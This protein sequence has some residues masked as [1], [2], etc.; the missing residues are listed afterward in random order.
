MKHGRGFTLIEMLVALAI[1][2][3]MSAMAW[4]GLDVLINSR[5]VARLKDESV[6][7]WQSAAQQW[8]LDLD[9]L[10]TAEASP[11]FQLAGTQAPEAII[12][13]DGVAILSIRSDEGL[14]VVA[15][16]LSPDAEGVMRW[17]RWASRPLVTLDQWR[18]A[19]AIAPRALADERAA[20]EVGHPRVQTVPLKTWQVEHHEL[21]RWSAAAN[22]WRSLSVP[23]GIRVTL[24]VHDDEALGSGSVLLGWSSALERGTRP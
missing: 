6:A 18:G 15:W 3:T 4:R 20:R 17:S 11:A 10:R 12:W 23:T 8:R 7:G 19:L 16:G 21:G 24:G 13:S 22:G 1:V 5:E 2:A 14:Q 9:R